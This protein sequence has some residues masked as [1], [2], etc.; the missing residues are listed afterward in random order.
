M[1]INY[2]LKSSLQIKEILMLSSLVPLKPGGSEREVESPITK[3]CMV[4]QSADLDNLFR[5][6]AHKSMS[7][8]SSNLYFSLLS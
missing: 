2:N 5:T 6:A 7:T 1:D 8:S 3:N 4:T